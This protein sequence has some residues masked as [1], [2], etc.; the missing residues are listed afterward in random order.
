MNSEK[1]RPLLN[2][3]VELKTDGDHMKGF[4][5]REGGEYYI[6]PIEVYKGSYS[7]IP[8][9]IRSKCYFDNMQS[10]TASK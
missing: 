2:K 8:A 9:R 4:L 10:Y 5:F 1:L 3:L 7:K 6:K